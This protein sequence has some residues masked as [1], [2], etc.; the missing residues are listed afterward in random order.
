MTKRQSAVKTFTWR[1]LASTDT[2]LI[3]LFCIYYLEYEHVEL[4]GAIAIIEIFNKLILYY[5]HERAWVYILNKLK[6]GGKLP[7]MLFSL[8]GVYKLGML[9]SQR[10]KS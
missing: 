4:A 1:F 5:L 3:S 8:C 7:F 6:E 10:S 9:S 2:F